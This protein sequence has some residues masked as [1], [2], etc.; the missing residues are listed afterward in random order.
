MYPSVRWIYHTWMDPMFNHQLV[1]FPIVDLDKPSGTLDGKTWTST[2]WP[3]CWR[4]TFRITPKTTGMV[5]WIR[6][7]C[8]PP[9]PQKNA[10]NFSLF[11][12]IWVNGHYKRAECHH[13]ESFRSSLVPVFCEHGGRI[14]SKGTKS[15][16]LN[17]ALR[18]R[19]WL[20]LQQTIRQKKRNV[21]CRSSRTRTLES[22]HALRSCLRFNGFAQG[23]EEGR[24]SGIA[25]TLPFWRAGAR[26]WKTWRSGIWCV[27]QKHLRDPFRV[28]R[29]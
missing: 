22:L 4:P 23:V 7:C 11:I 29:I 24:A 16:Q 1:V 20:G 17:M 8:P 9:P 2:T 5:D 18:V 14:W 28:W 3:S 6:A 27:C 21:W 15:H 12:N 26:G 13:L 10:L 25:F 19:P